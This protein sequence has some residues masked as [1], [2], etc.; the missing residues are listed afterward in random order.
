MRTLILIAVLG[1]IEVGAF[2]ISPFGQLWYFYN[3]PHP[4]S[5]LCGYNPGDPGH[6]HFGGKCRDLSDGKP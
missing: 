3:K 6:P 5:E 2:A 4:W 1:A